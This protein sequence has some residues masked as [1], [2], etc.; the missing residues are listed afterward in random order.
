MSDDLLSRMRGNNQGGWT[1]KDVETLCGQH[2]LSCLPPRRGSHYKVKRPG[3]KIILTI[4]FH[5]PIKP[6]YIRRLV[7]LIDLRLEG[8]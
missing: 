2:G 1:I 5:R 7:W 8:K 4:P 6:V 3:V